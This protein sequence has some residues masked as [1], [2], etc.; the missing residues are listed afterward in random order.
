MKFQ[1]FIF[2]LFLIVSSS[3]CGQI[4]KDTTPVNSQSEVNNSQ[5]AAVTVLTVQ[6]FKSK[7]DLPNAQIIDVRTDAEVADGMIPNA[8]QMDVLDW[9]GFVA[10]TK[11]LDPNKPVLVYC[12][13]GG[14]SSKAANYLVENGFTEV[15]DLSGGMT[16]WNKNKGEIVKP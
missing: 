14:R 1:I 16:N 8:V 10:S 6:E 11:S 15:Y 9:N 12:K 2:S 13:S 4:E 7:L 3:A 5:D